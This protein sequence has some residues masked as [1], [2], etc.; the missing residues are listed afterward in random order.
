M[1]TDQ[2]RGDMSSADYLTWVHPLQVKAL[3]QG[4]LTIRAANSFGAGWCRDRLGTKVT[5]LAT[6]LVGQDT[7]VVFQVE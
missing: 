3:N 4:T 2:L 1:I 5:R 6:A 7:S